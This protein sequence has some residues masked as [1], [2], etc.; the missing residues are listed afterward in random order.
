MSNRL[1]KKNVSEII[2]KLLKIM[3]MCYLLEIESTIKTYFV[4]CIFKM[5][6]SLLILIADFILN[7]TCYRCP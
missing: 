7:I 2:F 1:V 5:Y 4:C 6:Y 3:F